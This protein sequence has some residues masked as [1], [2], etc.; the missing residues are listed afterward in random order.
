MEKVRDAEPKP[1]PAPEPTAWA[2]F[3]ATCHPGTR[4]EVIG[5]YDWDVNGTNRA[6][7][8]P[9]LEL[10]CDSA[11]CR[12]IRFFDGSATGS[13]LQPGKFTLRYLEYTCRHCKETYKT[14][15][16]AVQADE[17]SKGGKALKIGEW[18]PFGPVIP[19]RVAK[20]VGPDWELFLKG[21]RSEAQGLGL[22]AFAY[23]RR[24]VEQQKDRLLDRMVSVS[25]RLGVGA[26]EIAKLQSAK[27]EQQFSRAV[28]LAKDAIPDTL[29]VRGHNPLTLLHRPLSKGLHGLSD[30]DCLELAQ[31]IRLVLTELADRLGQVLKDDSELTAAVGRLLQSNEGTPDG[32]GSGCG[33]S[34]DD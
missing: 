34:S 2:D 3:L 27:A 7:A 26:A 29:F 4:A 11:K 20:L 14:Y 10:H 8:T 19:A 21:R 12:G 28:E 22:G 13:W 31:A 23:Y 25:E 18:P 6:L 15:A 17:Y 1:D 16:V 24:V 33:T 5:L 30:E 32:S 9:V